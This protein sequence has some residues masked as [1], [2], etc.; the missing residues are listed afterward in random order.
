M[1]RLHGENHVF[2]RIGWLRAAVLG[3]ND[4]IISAASL[5]I[6]VAS[7]ANDSHEIMVAGFAGMIAKIGGASIFKP[8]L[9][10]AFWGAFA[11]AITTGNGLLVGQVV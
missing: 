10:V 9:L 2:Q 5:I 6:G 3:T 7:A 11:M 8:T 4:G 1:V